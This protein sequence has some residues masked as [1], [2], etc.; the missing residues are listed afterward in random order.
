MELSFDM[1]DEVLIA[2]LSGELD[3][4]R[5][6][7]AREALDSTAAAFGASSLVLD[8]SG[9]SFMDSSG[10]GVVMGRYNKMRERGG[11]VYLTGCSHFV[12]RILDMAGIFTIM[13]YCMTVEEAI[14]RAKGAGKEGAE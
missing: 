5:A 11:K 1:T 6:A 14:D 8:F 3:H 13:E 2:G 9:V 7:E 4:Y 12:K 10:V